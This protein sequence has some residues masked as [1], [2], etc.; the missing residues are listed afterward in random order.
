MTKL[1]SDTS[2]QIPFGEPLIVLITGTL[3]L[4]AVGV[5]GPEQADVTDPSFS[6]ANLQQLQK[7]KKH[8][9]NKQTPTMRPTR[10]TQLLCS[11]I[12]SRDASALRQCNLRYNNLS[13]H[14]PRP[15]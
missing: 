10:S 7:D 14:F 15:N 12:L 5:N 9:K 6:H 2:G 8:T 13:T 3:S 1:I 11:R 4:E